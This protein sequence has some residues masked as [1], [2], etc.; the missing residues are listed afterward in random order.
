MAEASGRDDMYMGNR[1]GQLNMANIRRRASDIV[2]QIDEL[3]FA[4]RSA[5]HLL[6]WRDVVDKYAVLNVQLQQLQEQLR[7]VA[8]HYALHP[9][10][11][12]QMNSVTLP[13]ML[14]SRLYPE[15]EKEG[16]EAVRAEAGLNREAGV[17]PGRWKESVAEICDTMTR[18]NG[19]LDSRSAQRRRMFVRKRDAVAIKSEQD[20]ERE[21]AEERLLHLVGFGG[22]YTV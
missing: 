14:A 19:I 5:P 13:I 15:Q 21:K 1:P 7:P 22:Q 2:Q 3:L 18:K 17:D 8:H 10:S 20:D 6:Q 4:L 16:D 11:V 9:K 12:N